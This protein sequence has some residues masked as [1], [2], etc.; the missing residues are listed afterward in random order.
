MLFEKR[1]SLIGQGRN[2]AAWWEKCD[3]Q[4]RGSSRM[5]RSPTAASKKDFVRKNPG[6]EAE[7]TSRAGKNLETE[8]LQS[9]FLGVEC[10]RE[11]STSGT[12]VLPQRNCNT[13]ILLQKADFGRDSKVF[14]L[15]CNLFLKLFFWK[16]RWCQILS[17]SERKPEGGEKY[18]QNTSCA[19]SW[20]SGQWHTNQ[21][22]NKNQKQT[23]REPA[24]HK[25]EKTKASLS[26]T[27][28]KKLSLLWADCQSASLHARSAFCASS[29]A[30]CAGDFDR[31]NH[32]FSLC[33]A[34]WAR[35]TPVSGE[36][37]KDRKQ[38]KIAKDVSKSYCIRNHKKKN[39]PARTKTPTSTQ[40]KQKQPANRIWFLTCDRL[41][42]GTNRM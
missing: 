35:L 2:H 12:L 29:N 36:N 1:D 18:G 40:N 7:K 27:W 13:K 33:R 16:C 23:K 31:H 39:K 14:F 6:N 30:V 21:P 24:T 17:S 10:C 32:D 20:L 38:H 28:K 5:C 41:W 8:K 42:V 22:R 11:K 34:N 3:C 19:W 25:N 37:S 26:Q 15:F 9:E 4:V